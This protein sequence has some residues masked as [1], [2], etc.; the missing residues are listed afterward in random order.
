MEHCRLPAVC[1]DVDGHHEVELGLD[2]FD[3]KNLKAQ[4]PETLDPAQPAPGISAVQRFV[5]QCAAYD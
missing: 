2:L 3:K 4:P 1:S 5:R